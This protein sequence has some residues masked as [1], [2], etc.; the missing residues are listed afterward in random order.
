MKSQHVMLTKR[1]AGFCFLLLAGGCACMPGPQ[2]PPRE[3]QPAAPVPQAS[4]PAEPPK[5]GAPSA[6]VPEVRAPSET[7]APKPSAPRPAPAPAASKPIARTEPPAAPQPAPKKP[8]AAPA[9]EAPRPSAPT[10]DL[11]SLETRL[12]ETNAIGVMTK[13]TL[14]GQVEDL[15]DRFRAYHDGKVRIQLAELRQPYDT[16]ILKVLALL[17]DKDPPLA[18]AIAGSREAI[19][20]ILADRAK[21]LK[22]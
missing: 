6:A 15:L 7:A 16:L 3:P 14:K 2:P 8:A 11:K 5:P 10:L 12:R 9:A 19:W 1:L 4:I 18:S 17:Q 20:A 22:L 21:F 13:L